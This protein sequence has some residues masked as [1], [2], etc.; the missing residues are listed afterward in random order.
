MFKYKLGS[1]AKDKLSGYQGTV[2]ARMEWYHGCIRY[3]VQSPEL[4]EGKPVESQSFDE[5]QVK[6]TKTPRS[7][8]ESNFT[9]ELNS[10]VKDV[11]TGFTGRITCRVQWLYGCNRYGV[12]SEELKDGKP[13]DAVF[14]DEGM[15]QLLEAAKPHEMTRTGGTSITPPQ[16]RTPPR[17]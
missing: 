1:T 17:H 15:L 14:Y 8:V 12:Q 5:E 4:H 16:H 2:V 7:D 9:Y 6:V 10:K 13:I 3:V 11:V